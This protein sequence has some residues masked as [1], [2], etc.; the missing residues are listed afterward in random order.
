MVTYLLE[1]Q[2]FIG[3]PYRE[4]K[5]T[6]QTP[7]TKRQANRP[8]H[9]LR[10]IKTKVVGVTFDGRQAVVAKLTMGEEVVLRGELTNPYDRNAIR[11][12]RLNGE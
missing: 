6:T 3:D 8:T 1:T 10:E 7:V 4:H 12:E 2:H 11:V 5:P 9:R